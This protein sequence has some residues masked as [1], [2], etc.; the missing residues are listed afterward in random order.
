LIQK[1]QQLH[2][3]PFASSECRKL[4][5]RYES[6]TKLGE[7]SCAVVYRA[8]PLSGDQDVALKVM[9][10]QDEERLLIAKKE[11]DLLTKVSHPNIIR[12]LD[13]FTFPMGAV[14][15]LEFFEGRSLEVSVLEA[16][17]ACLGEAV[18]RNLFLQ[19]LQAVAHLHTHSVLHRDIKPDNILVSADMADLRLVDFNAAK[20]LIEGGA[21]T[22]TGTVNYMSPEVL[23]G[24]S[25]SEASDIWAVG[26][27]LH[28]MLIGSLPSVRNGC[29]MAGQKELCDKYSPVRLEDPNWQ[30]VS[31]VCKSMV[32]KC[33]DLNPEVRPQAQTL[34]SDLMSHAYS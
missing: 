10:M 9:R 4:A 32:L 33:L 19:L 14:L 28:F 6:F 15:V 29:F 12:A 17:G 30:E 25:P 26:L 13:F 1:E 20:N 24:T 31:E 16:K 23:E 21:L 11:F 18:A 8:K 34:L 2:A 3:D 5:D 22:M 27:C 7:G